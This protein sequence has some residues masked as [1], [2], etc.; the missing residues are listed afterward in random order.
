MGL[1]DGFILAIG[2]YLS[3]VTRHII[4]KRFNESTI[5]VV[6]TY[7]IV[8]C[9]VIFFIT[10]SATNG[11]KL[12][13][14][15]ILSYA[16]ISTLGVMLGTKFRDIVFS[17]T[18]VDAEGANFIDPLTLRRHVLENEQKIKAQ[19]DLENTINRQ[20]EQLNMLIQHILGDEDG[21]GDNKGQNGGEKVQSAEIQTLI[22]QYKAKQAA[23]LPPPVH[24]SSLE[25]AESV[26]R[27]NLFVDKRSRMRNTF[28]NTHKSFNS[29]QS[30]RDVALLNSVPGTSPG[31]S[32][33]SSSTPTSPHT[34]GND[35]V[36]EQKVT[37]VDENSLKHQ[38]DL[39]CLQPNDGTGAGNYE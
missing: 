35:E 16:V 26:N 19:G 17:D 28:Q 14:V 3:I 23:N 5:L 22:Q 38:S 15:A 33:G 24:K 37:K 6:D 32:S 1:Y 39:D 10:L 18:V 2:V 31:I 7:N 20:E 13:Q 27:S 29:T 30:K 4:D 36:G 11:N 9:A 25:T 8:V 34:E 12:I 21:E